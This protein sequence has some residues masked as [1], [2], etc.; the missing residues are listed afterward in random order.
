MMEGSAFCNTGSQR[1]DHLCFSTFVEL[2]GIGSQSWIF[3]FYCSC[4]P[5]CEGFSI[6]A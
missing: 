4:G 5:L 6:A 1:F 3:T 2:F